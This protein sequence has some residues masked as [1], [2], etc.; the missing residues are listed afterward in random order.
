MIFFSKKKYEKC[1]SL[2]YIRI[3]KW[4]TA[5]NTHATHYLKIIF[6]PKKERMVTKKTST[7]KGNHQEEGLSKFKGDIPL[8]SLLVRLHN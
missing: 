6:A 8:A 3:K 7:K 1:A 2:Y 4:A 5:H